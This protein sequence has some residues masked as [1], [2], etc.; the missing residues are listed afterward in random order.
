MLAPKW[1]TEMLVTG[2]DHLEVHDGWPNTELAHNLRD[3]GVSRINKVSDGYDKAIFLHMGIAGVVPPE[4]IPL[5][6]TLQLLLEENDKVRSNCLKLVGLDSDE[7]HVYLRLGDLV[8]YLQTWALFTERE[9]VEIPELD[10]PDEISH[11]WLGSGSD[12]I[13]NILWERGSQPRYF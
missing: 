13:R 1:I 3:I 9:Q 2:E 12:Q 4:L 5:R 8:P 7:K 10:F 6:D 11:I